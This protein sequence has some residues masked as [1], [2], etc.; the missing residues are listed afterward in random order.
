MKLGRGRHSVLRRTGRR[1]ILAAVLAI[2]GVGAGLRLYVPAFRPG[3]ADASAGLQLLF[4]AF[5]RAGGPQALYVADSEGN[6]RRVSPDDGRTYD[7][8]TWAFGGQRVVFTARAG[9]PGNPENLFLMDPDGSNV[10]QLTVNTW[11]NAQPK[12][13]P[14]GTRV[15]FTSQWE[16]YPEVALYS[17][18]LATLEVTNVSAVASTKGA[19]DSDPRWSAD[20]GSIVFAN[21]VGNG[22]TRPTQI[23]LMNSDGTGRRAVTDDS[24]Y[25]TDPS[26]SPNGEFVATASY[27]GSGHPRRDDA[28]DPL[29]VK[30]SDW[31]LVT[32]AV[33]GR[34]E[35]VLTNGEL[36]A[37]RP[38]SDP[39]SPEQGSA[40]V[41]I[42]S[43]DG[44]SIGYIGI[45]SQTSV[46]ICMIDAGGT[47]PRVLFKSD[48]LAITWWDWN[49][50]SA[51]QA[52]VPAIG[53]EVRSERLLVSG[54]GSDGGR[55]LVTYGPDRWAGF[56][57]LLRAPLRLIPEDARWTPD[58]RKIVFVA[59][60]P[61][62]IEAFEP[63]PAAAPP[64]ERRPH[65]TLDFVRNLFEPAVQRPDVAGKQV[66]LM[67]ADGSGLRQL[68]DPWI[69]DYADGLPDGE[70]RGNIDPDVSPD[71]RYVV[72]TN[73]SST[74]HESAI[75]RLDLTTGEVYN[76][77]SAT[78]GAIPVAD[79]H[80]RFSPDGRRVAFVSTGITNRLYVVNAQDGR[81]LVELSHDD[82]FTSSPA[83]SPDG[84][85]IAFVSYRGSELPVLEGDP[86]EPGTSQRIRLDEWYLVRVDVRTGFQTVLTGSKE[87]PAF[88]PVWSPDGRRIAFISMGDVPQPDIYVINADGTGRRPLQVTLRS[89]EEYV[90]WR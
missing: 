59:E 24:F 30:L 34:G 90:D 87:S 44:S 18:D 23:Y 10:V 32:R 22:E 7:W 12:V 50:P 4:A 78:A 8:G 25:N 1:S 15:L 17:L 73:V 60:M 42:W 33:G 89:H 36:C 81:G 28:T 47:N 52:G 31:H 79:A 70:A 74:T 80:P 2:A 19:F 51:A 27:R 66:F 29:D 71:G 69:E 5:P 49:D 75:L 39:C 83:W 14:D 68:T 54:S 58:R 45:L 6:V 26:L 63:H 37:A 72:F 46:C 86:L 9:L 82:Y 85:S 40:F 35:R 64:D 43:L 67:D 13:S 65:F 88:N 53:R 77:S 84:R 20:G 76:L 57:V 56:P 62:D 21:S 48:D 38:A 61:Y 41:P 16:E 11:R 55:G 3:S